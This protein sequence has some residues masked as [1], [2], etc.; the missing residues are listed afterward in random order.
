MA[1]HNSQRLRRILTSP[2]ARSYAR[3]VSLGRDVSGPPTSPGETSR[4]RSVPQMML[5]TRGTGGDVFPFIRIGAALKRRGHEVVLLSYS[6]FKGVAKKAGLAF[7]PFDPFM[8]Y[9]DWLAQ[10]GL[11]ESAA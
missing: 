3:R 9:A 8:P 6:G 1:A 4:G 5:L 7:V 2:A 11:K 10:Q